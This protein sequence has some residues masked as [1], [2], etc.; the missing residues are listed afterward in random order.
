M[1]Y[2]PFTGIGIQSVLRFRLLFAYTDSAMAFGFPVSVNRGY[3]PAVRRVE[4]LP[5][6]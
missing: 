2:A 6:L 5:A 4:A 1:G 3:L